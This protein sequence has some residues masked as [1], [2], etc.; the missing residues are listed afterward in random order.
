MCTGD[1][2][3]IS[4]CSYEG[5]DG[6][7]SCSHYDDIF[8]FCACKDMKMII[9]T[10]GVVIIFLTSARQ[11]SEGDIRLDGGNVEVCLDGLWGSV[12][13]GGKLDFSTTAVVC[14]QLYNNGYI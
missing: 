6:D 14:R 7:F 9:I 3:R 10:Q 2:Q 5:P 13:D 4:E 11:C 1:E 12:C 8:I